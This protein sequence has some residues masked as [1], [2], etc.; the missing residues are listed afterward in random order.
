L[1]AKFI[2]AEIYRVFCGENG[3]K[4][5]KLSTFA[6]TIGFEFGWCEGKIVHLKMLIF[7]VRIFGILP[8]SSAKMGRKF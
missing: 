1:S 2:L 5:Q 4:Y 7:G 3:T 6:S 8:P